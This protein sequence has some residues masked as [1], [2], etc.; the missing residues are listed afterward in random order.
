M[1][2]YEGVFILDPDMS[3]ES[4]KGTVNTIQELM[5]TRTWWAR[6]WPGTRASTAQASP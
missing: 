3:S 4:S 6:M 2:S 1:K 5:I